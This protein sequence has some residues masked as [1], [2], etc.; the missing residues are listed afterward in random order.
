VSPPSVGITFPSDDRMSAVEFGAFAEEQ[1][2]ESLWFSEH[3]HIPVS[4]ESQFPG[5]KPLAPMYLRFPDPFVS[6]AAIA[7]TTSRVRLGTG[8]CLLTQRDP[9]TTAKEIATLDNVSGGRVLFGVGAG[10]NDE[11]LRNHGTDPQQ[12]FGVLVERADAIRTIWTQE[13]AEFHGRFVSFAPI[14]SYPKP[15]QR[16]HPPILL[17]GDGPR[18]PGRALDHGDGWI[19]NH[20]VNETPVILERISEVRERAA[21]DGRA[22]AITLFASPLDRDLLRAYIEAGVSRFVFSLRPT[23]HDEPEFDRLRRAIGEVEAAA[24]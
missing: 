10:W 11:E 2:A 17:A 12:K 3:T 21:R 5:G 24:G 8:L 14:W 23:P 18:A 13:E 22:F 15:L 4:R 19:T 7:A 20:A 1:G 9:I 6:L 16:P